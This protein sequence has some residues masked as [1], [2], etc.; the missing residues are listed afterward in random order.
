MRCRLRILHFPA[1]SFLFPDIFQSE[2]IPERFPV[3]LGFSGI[4]VRS[5]AFPA[6]VSTGRPEGAC[7]A[8]FPGFRR[9][10]NESSRYPNRFSSIRP[11]RA[12]YSYLALDLPSLRF[13]A[14]PKPS[15]GGLT[16]RR[17]CRERNRFYAFHTVFRVTRTDFHRL[18][19][20]GRLN[21]ELPQLPSIR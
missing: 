4:S 16:R 1:N 17:V 9:S 6:D 19:P 12:R 14:F 7:F 11:Q 21:R 8:C 13:T 2:S 3:A 5:F 20:E 18:D 15:L 10:T